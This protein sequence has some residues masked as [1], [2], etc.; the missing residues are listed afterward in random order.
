MAKSVIDRL[1]LIEIDEEHCRQL[2]RPTTSK[3]GVVK[4]LEEERPVWQSR[5]RVVE[6]DLARAKD[7]IVKVLSRLRIVEVG[8]R[9][10]RE[11][12]G[13]SHC[14]R[15]KTSP[16]VAVQIECAEP[17]VTV[18]QWKREDRSETGIDRPRRKA[19]ESGI[20]TQVR[21]RD[22]VAGLVRR[23]AW[24]LAKLRLQSLELQRR[25]I[26]S[27]QEARGYA[28]RDDG[29][30]GGRNGQHVDNSHHQ[31][32]EYALDREVRHQRVGEL[33]KQI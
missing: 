9:D 3:H 8:G 15:A 21:D 10:I 14:R 29:Y 1:E 33:T 27:C 22:R 6:C 5:Q 24:T 11:R 7:G 32:I 25:I 28:R 13:G 17:M 4:S 16:S 20:R 18:A 30:A 2:L 31:M 19:G 23:K 26:R 12:L